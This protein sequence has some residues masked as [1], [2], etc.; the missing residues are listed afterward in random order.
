MIMNRNDVGGSR[1]GLFNALSG[2]SPKSLMKATKY[3]IADLQ[4]E[5]GTS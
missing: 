3:R 5:P 1:W 2:Y 4:Y